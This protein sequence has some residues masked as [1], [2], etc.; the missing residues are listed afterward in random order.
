[1]KFQCSCGAKYAIDVTPGMPPVTFVCQNCKQDYSAFINELIRKELGQSAVPAPAQPAAP[2]LRI[3]SGHSAPSAPPAQPAPSAPPPPAAPP[4]SE[5]P[6]LRINKGHAAEPA[7]PAAAGAP[8]EQAHT[9]KYCSRH[10]TELTTDQCQ[11]CHKPI[12][13][14]CLETF[15]P[16][17]S[18][19]C[20][21]KVEGASMGAVVHV[22]QRQVRQNVFWNKTGTI[23]KIGGSIAFVLAVFWF[24][25]AWFGS[26]PHK[27]LSFAG[28]IFRIRELPALSATTNCFSCMAARWPVII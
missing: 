25:Y 19:F 21:N 12:C 17:C 16:F 9:S 8:Q 22:G 15:G 20:R 23:A 24:W 27:A 10:K 6:R 28:M 1:M 11:I 7:A 3:A 2:S 26:V 14:Q 18:P 4:A 5:G 13:P